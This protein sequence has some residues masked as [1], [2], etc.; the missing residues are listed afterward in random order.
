[1]P[2][3]L[4]KLMTSVDEVSTQD[5]VFVESGGDV[6]KIS[7]NALLPFYIQAGHVSVSSGTASVTFG[8][9]FET[10]P[11]VVATYAT[12]GSSTYAAYNEIVITDITKNGFNIKLIGN[13][14][15]TFT[16][17]WLA[18]A[19]I[20]IPSSVA[21]GVT[22]VATTLDPGD[23]AT[24]TAVETN[25]G[26]EFI[27]GVPKGEKGDTGAQ[28]PQGPE[29]PAGS[30]GMTT[31]PYD[32][33]TGPSGLENYLASIVDCY[34]DNDG[35][36]LQH[37]SGASR[38]NYYPI[39]TN[40]VSLGG[41]DNRYEFWLISQDGYIELNNI[42]NVFDA[43]SLEISVTHPDDPNVPV[44]TYVYK[45]KTL[46]LA[47]VSYLNNQIA[48][49]EKTA[50]KKSIYYSY[51]SDKTTKYLSIAGVENAINSLVTVDRVFYK[52]DGFITAGNSSMYFYFEID[53]S[54]REKL[55][56]VILRG[57]KLT[58]SGTDIT[59]AD[60]FTDFTYSLVWNLAQWELLVQLNSVQATD[61]Y[62]E[63][64][65]DTEINV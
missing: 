46:T 62:F 1:M 19:G 6:K 61:I 45:E 56:M 58:Y 33:M 60:L 2:A 29:G 43:I 48:T 3:E 16:I 40:K 38:Q 51:E 64:W 26:F 54:D 47:S 5:Y 49:C 59:Q 24:A 20:T 13:N 18:F 44:Y 12:G 57:T 41:N 25:D 63:L 55:P 34:D 4:T 31:F 11:R 65:S 23:P 42:K 15:G 53:A 36:I 9:A 39:S 8:T 30:G 32:G 27:F 37:F 7:R 14:V 10:T 22:A 35:F 50:N 21:Y 28:G 52:N 17:D